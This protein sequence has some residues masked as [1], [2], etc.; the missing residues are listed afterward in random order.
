MISYL[1]PAAK[2]SRASLLPRHIEMN[3]RRERYAWGFMRFKKPRRQ[4]CILKIAIIDKRDA[5][6]SLPDD[7][8]AT[9]FEN[10]I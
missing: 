6:K 2:N 1:K 8:M 9:E 3:I 10:Y 4:Y 7:I 5:K